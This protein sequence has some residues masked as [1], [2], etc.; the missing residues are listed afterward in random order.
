MLFEAK[1]ISFR[2]D[3]KSPWIFKDISLKINSGERVGLIAP[4]G[5]GKS[6]LAKVLAGYEK[7]SSGS[8]TI[9]SNAIPNKGYCPVQLIFQHPELS[10]N[11]RWKMDRILNE[12]GEVS[13]AVLEKLGIHKQWLT[14]WPSELSGGELQRFCIARV[15]NDRTRFLICDEITTMLD[16]IT[17][18]Q[19]WEVLMEISKSKNMGMLVITH[20]SHIV[21]RVCDRVIDLAE[22]N[23]C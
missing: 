19:I 23:Q 11:P 20:N 1:N 6:T 15:L 3:E 9:D 8:I 21:E 17:Q 13:E 5:Y 18:A 4:S 7:A 16:A 12:A 10:V 2:Y 22:I 14:R